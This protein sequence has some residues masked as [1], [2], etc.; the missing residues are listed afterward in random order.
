MYD[1]I[2]DPYTY[3]NSTVLI[4]KLDLRE[5]AELDAF[6]AEISNARADEPL[7]EGNLDFTHYKAVHHHLFQDVYEWAG[8]ARTVRMSKGGNSFCFP[9]NIETQTTKLFGELQA[10][11]FLQGLDGPAFADRAAHFLAELNAI[12]AFREGNGRSQL[13]FFILLADYAGHL[14]DLDKLDPHK[15]LDAMI[16]SFDGHEAKLANVIKDLIA[17]PKVPG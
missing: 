16:A 7:P 13:T 6:E 12:H 4:N 5:Q 17:D 9:E 14:I 3:E 8:M 15:M 2:D 10:D 1:A 11:D